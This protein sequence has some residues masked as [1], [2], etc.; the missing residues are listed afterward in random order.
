MGGVSGEAD[1]AARPPPWACSASSRRRAPPT[2]T[3]HTHAHQRPHPYAAE[4][5]RSGRDSALSFTLCQAS[6]SKPPPRASEKL[7]STTSQTSAISSRP[8]AASGDGAPCFGSGVAEC[9][10]SCDV[11][12]A[13][14]R[15]AQ[16]RAVARFEQAAGGRRHNL[17]LLRPIPAYCTPGLRHPSPPP[18]RCQRA[19][20]LAARIPGAGPLPQRPG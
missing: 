18:Q 13:P 1:A 10:R 9:M 14:R 5:S 7:F 8:S 2:H 3:A 17:P 20:Q 11:L 12:R 16:A 6:R 15:G 4:R 19:H